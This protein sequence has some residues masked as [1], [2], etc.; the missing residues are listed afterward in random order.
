[1]AKDL[2]LADLIKKIEGDLG[3]S[4]WVTVFEISD[5]GS[6][7]PSY[8]SALITN[9]KVKD[10]EKKHEWDMRI[11]DGRPGFISCYKNGKPKTDYYRFSNKG[12]EPFIH[13]RTFSGKNVAPLRT[14]ATRKIGVA[15]G[16]V[17]Y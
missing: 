16:S 14:V 3:K 5:T 11:G 15:Q 6:E 7:N 12:I 9:S 17:Q 4:E 10:V 2:M 1:M 8:F 13:Y